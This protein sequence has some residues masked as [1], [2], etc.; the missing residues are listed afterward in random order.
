MWIHDS[1]LCHLTLV[2]LNDL[3]TTLKGSV[4]YK[5]GDGVAYLHAFFGNRVKK[6]LPAIACEMTMTSLIRSFFSG[7]C[8]LPLS[9]ST[10]P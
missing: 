3:P 10:H 2:L 7:G 4:G 5:R 6:L 9:L 8:P 1:S